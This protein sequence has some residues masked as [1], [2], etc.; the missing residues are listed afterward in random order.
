MSLFN[1]SAVGRNIKWVID[2]GAFTSEDWDCV[3]DL[4]R[5]RHPQFS[6]VDCVSNN[7]KPLVD[8]L[9]KYTSPSGC[10]LLVDNV[11]DVEQMLA[12]RLWFRT[13]KRFVNKE[14]EGYVIFACVP[15]PSWVRALWQLDVRTGDWYE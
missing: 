1:N 5:E 2:C 9:N 6:H 7:A 12:A 10:V 8:R 4:I 14:V 11:L 15:C 3:A 13:R